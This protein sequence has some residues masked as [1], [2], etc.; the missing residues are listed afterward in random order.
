[1]IATVTQRSAFLQR[2]EVRFAMATAIGFGI[3]LLGVW[4]GR[5]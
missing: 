2:K 3:L 1:V 5:T 4:I